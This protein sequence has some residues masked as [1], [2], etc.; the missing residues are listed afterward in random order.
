[1]V[2]KDGSRVIGVETAGYDYLKNCVYL[3]IT[4]R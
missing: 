2:K 1:M 4:D 3:N